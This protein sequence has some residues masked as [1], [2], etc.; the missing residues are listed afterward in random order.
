MK[1]ERDDGTYREPHVARE[2]AGDF[3]HFVFY[4]SSVIG[5]ISSSMLHNAQEINA[6]MDSNKIFEEKKEE[7][8]FEQ[9]RGYPSY[10]YRV[11]E[12]PPN[13]AS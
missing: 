9:M 10:K 11:P 7:I 4:S 8:N 13:A 3:D 12:L 6:S 1:S 5:Y 2:K